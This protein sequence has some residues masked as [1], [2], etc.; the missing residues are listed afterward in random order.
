MMGRGWWAVVGLL[1]ALSLALRHSLLFLMGAL[2]A[3]LGGFSWLWARYSLAG[4]SYRRRFAS[5]RLFLGE[6]RRR[7]PGT[8]LDHENP[9]HRG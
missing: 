7:R 8:D 1:L 6:E 3:L 2:L 9:T 5:T 4:V